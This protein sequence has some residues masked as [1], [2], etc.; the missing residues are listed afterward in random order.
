VQKAVATRRW[1]G[2]WYTIFVAID[3]AGG[4]AV[5]ADFEAEMF[6]HLERYRMAGVDVE[7][8]GPIFVPLDIALRVCVRPGYFRSQV[9]QQLL[10]VFSA[11]DL[12][13]GTR[14]FFH[15]DHFT[16]GQPVYLSRIYQTA[17]AVDGVAWVEATRF[18]RWGEAPNRRLDNGILVNQDIAQGALTA[19]RL[20]VLRLDNDPNFAENGKID[21]DMLGGL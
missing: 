20:E 6:A 2:S 10:R 9:K 21:F 7:I 15:P 1:T 14:G 17:T 16:F 11:Q 8:D 13:D 3:R 12:G 18:Q 4:R 19:D 5:D